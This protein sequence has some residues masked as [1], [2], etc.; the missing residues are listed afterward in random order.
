MK[1]QGTISVIVGVVGFV[2]FTYLL[3]DSKI[4]ALGYSSL[5]GLLAIVCIVI[6]VLSRLKEL[7]LK[8]LKLTLDKIEEAKKEIYAKEESLKETSH[9]LAELIAANSTL[10]GIWGDDESNSYSKDLIRAKIKKLAKQMEFSTEE[11]EQILKYEKA[12]AEVHKAPKEEHDQ[13]W[14]DFKQLLKA[15]AEQNA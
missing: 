14:N 8:N 15:E 10:T 5:L 2:T 1:T 13:K 6:P 12:L 4:G 7:D 3:I 9:V 11:M